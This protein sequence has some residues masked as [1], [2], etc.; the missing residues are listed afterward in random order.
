MANLAE[1]GTQVACSVCAIGTLCKARGDGCESP[2]TVEARLRLAPGERLYNRGTP[3][4]AIFA[5]R[6]GFLKV[7]GPDGGGGHHITQFLLPGDV[8]GLD[9]FAGGV[10]A[11]E[12]VSLEDTEVCR[13]PAWRVELLAEYNERS[14]TCIRSL[15]ARE[16]AEACTHGAAVA[17]LSAARRVAKLLLDLGRRWS[18]RGY[19]AVEFRLPMQRREMGEYLGLTTETVSR[20]FSDFRNHGWIALPPHAVVLLEPESLQRVLNGELELE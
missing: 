7:C 12:A 1:L 17:H 15:L 3:A 2:A 5:V 19:S 14:R 13:V 6:A 11:S 8:A 10:Y 20:T 18:E 4:D 16:L 9:A